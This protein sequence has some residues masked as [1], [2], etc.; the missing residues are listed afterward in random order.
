MFPFK[1]LHAFNGVHLQ[2]TDSSHCSPQSRMLSPQLGMCTNFCQFFWPQASE[3]LRSPS[4]WFSTFCV[5]ALLPHTGFRFD[6][7]VRKQHVLDVWFAGL[8]CPGHLVIGIHLSSILS[9]MPL[10]NHS[11]SSPEKSSKSSRHSIFNYR[12][13]QSDVIFKSLHS[14]SQVAMKTEW[15][16]CPRLTVSDVWMLILDYSGV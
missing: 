5:Y 2:I 4:H 12:E 1:D 13:R 10:H 14:C 6:E 3:S 8:P 7:H 16:G 11:L 15:W 9:H